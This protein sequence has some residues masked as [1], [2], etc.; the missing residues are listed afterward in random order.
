MSPG[1]PP[2]LSSIEQ[3]SEEN[4]QEVQKLLDRMETAITEAEQLPA[5]EQEFHKVHE[6]ALDRLLGR[7]GFTVDMPVAAACFLEEFHHA[8]TD[9]TLRA[10]AR[11]DLADFLRRRY[12]A[13]LTA[14]AL[15]DT[16]AG[17][18]SDRYIYTRAEAARGMLYAYPLDHGLVPETEQEAWVQQCARI[19]WEA[20]G[21]AQTISDEDKKLE[22]SLFI[23][24]RVTAQVALRSRNSDLRLRSEK[25][26]AEFLSN[27]PPDH[28]ETIRLQY[29]QAIFIRDRGEQRQAGHMLTE[30]A[31]AASID[32]VVDAFSYWVLAGE[33]FLAAGHTLVACSCLRQ[34]TRLQKEYDKYADKAPRKGDVEKYEALKASIT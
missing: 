5:N 8:G 26:V 29:I 20:F 22:A 15:L 19:L 33:C 12:G 30:C 34:A 13:L 7:N 14:E 17:E 21:T 6:Q 25:T 10:A 4:R 27:L 32:A 16:I 3:L 23:L 31:L 18:C 1:M 2:S 28:S 9:R 24:H 11:T